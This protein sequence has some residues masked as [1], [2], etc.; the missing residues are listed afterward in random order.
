MDASE[1][2]AARTRLILRRNEI[3]KG[4]RART[5]SWPE[6]EQICRAIV[7]LD[8]KIYAATEV[9]RDSAQSTSRASS[10]S[11]PQ[12]TRSRSLLPTGKE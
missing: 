12:L 11:V 4:L 8:R 1:L 2:K 10:V 5:E 7:E 3:I 6:F 9:D